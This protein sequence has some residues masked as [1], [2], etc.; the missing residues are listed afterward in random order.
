MI[1]EYG[2]ALTYDGRPTDALTY[3]AM[4]KEL[5]PFIPDWYLWCEGG[6]LFQS[7]RYAEAIGVLQTMTDPSE[8]G[9]LLAASYAYLGDSVRAAHWAARVRA[10][11]PLFSAENWAATQPFRKTEDLEHFIHALRQAGLE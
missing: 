3:I 5:N 4:A 1:A 11:H 8:A 2:D 6:A 10:K 7:H 9:R